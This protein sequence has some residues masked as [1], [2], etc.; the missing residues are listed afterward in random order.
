MTEQNG[1]HGMGFDCQVGAL[2]VDIGLHHD[3]S[4]PF[5][6]EERDVTIPGEDYVDQIREQYYEAEGNANNALHVP[7]KKDGSDFKLED[8]SEE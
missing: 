5:F 3:W 1:I 7:K 8:L 6:N 2:D 4:K